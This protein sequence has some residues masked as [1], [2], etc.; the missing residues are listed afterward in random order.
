MTQ[1][2]SI[3]TLLAQAGNRRMSALVRFQRQFIFNGLWP[4]WD[5][6]KYWV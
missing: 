2:Y 5:W 1:Q 3:D 4:S 6:R